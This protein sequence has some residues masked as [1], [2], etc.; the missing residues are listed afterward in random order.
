MTGILADLFTFLQVAIGL[1]LIFIIMLQRGKGG[2]LVGAL[3][4]M[5]GASA[6][7]PKADVQVLKLTI[8]LA[9]AWV[10]VACIGIFFNRSYTLYENE[11][12][13]VAKAKKDADKKEDTSG[14]ATNKDVPV[15][16][17]TKGPAKNKNEAGASTTT[18]KDK[19]L[20]RLEK[21]DATGEKN[22]FEDPPVKAK[23]KP[24]AA[25]LDTTKQPTVP[26]PTSEKPEAKPAT[27]AESEKP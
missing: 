8:G 25:K 11:S 20:P 24:G 12:D 13:A 17:E 27:K 10:I 7:G 1:F 6:F 26:V 23:P 9:L 21:D 4:G 22:P 18:T 16:V 3:G 19:P 2:G 14:G 5:G 15:G